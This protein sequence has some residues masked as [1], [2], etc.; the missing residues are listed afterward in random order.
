MRV[1]FERTE[2]L[3]RS[4]G[5]SVLRS[6]RYETSSLTNEMNRLYSKLNVLVI[7]FDDITDFSEE[8][9]NFLERVE[10]ARKEDRKNIIIL[11]Q[12]QLAKR[13]T[14]TLLREKKK[15]QVQKLPFS[16]EASSVYVKLICDDNRNIRYDDYNDELVMEYAKV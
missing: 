4:L 10:E 14:E 3:F 1:E 8:L 12:Y 2:R 16:K 9:S 6:V 7:C 13:Y 15:V 11:S 5:T